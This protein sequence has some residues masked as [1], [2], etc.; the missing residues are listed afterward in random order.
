MGKRNATS[1]V[2]TDPEFF[3]RRTEDN[4]LVSAIPFIKGTKEQPALLE[5]GGNMQRDNVAVEFAT[6]PVCGR[7]NFIS[8]IRRTMMEV[9]N[10]L[11]SGHEI[12][13]ESSAYFDEKELEH[14]EAQRFGCDP[15]FCAWCVKQNDPPVGPKPTFRSCGGHIHVGYIKDS[16]N[17]FL[18][19][20]EGKLLTVRSMDLFHGIISVIL[21]NAAE[22]IERRN[23]Y[24][25]AGSHRPTDYGIEYRALSNYWMKS[26]FLAAL[27]YSLTEDVLHLI[28][29]GKAE[30]L[31]KNVTGDVIQDVINSG[32][33][34]DAADIMQNIILPNISGESKELFDN[35]TGDNNVMPLAKAW[36]IGG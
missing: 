34:S 32:K 31:I 29:Q 30:P 23:L 15:D 2:G 36:S 26:P 14:E 1:T 10:K 9:M 7:T 21:D 28:R 11:P 20:F 6:P 5:G 24:G 16:G 25:K 4:K 13:A 19:D 33:E 12:V 35:C 27:M 22:S 18:L 3:L 8:V 17:D